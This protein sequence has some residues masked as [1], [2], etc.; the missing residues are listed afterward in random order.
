MIDDSPFTRR[1]L[2]VAGGGAAAAASIPGVLF[3]QPAGARTG[4]RW[5]ARRTFAS[6]IGQTFKMRVDRYATTGLELVSVTG[7][8]RSYDL[9]F[10][11]TSDVVRPQ[12]TRQLWHPEL[13]RT[14]LFVV[15]LQAPQE[16]LLY[17]VSIN[18][19]PVA[20]GSPAPPKATRRR[21]ET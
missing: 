9:V 21:A 17:V 11:P 7:D 13:G 14:Q 18:R 19:Q 3:P 2:L 4:A 1:R 16:P 12:A 10:R 5:L 8:D 20:P 15:P 6:R